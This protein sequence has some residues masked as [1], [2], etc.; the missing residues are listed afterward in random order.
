MAPFLQRDELDRVM[1][2]RNQCK[3]LYSKALREAGDKG[4]CKNFRKLNVVI[5]GRLMKRSII[6]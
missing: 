1:A 3:E 4:E 6:G 2:L 5:S